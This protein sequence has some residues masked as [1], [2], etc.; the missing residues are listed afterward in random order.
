M[1]F[2]KR[3]SGLSY[4]EARGLEKIGMIECHML[5]AFNVTGSIELAL[6]DQQVLMSQLPVTYPLWAEPRHLFMQC[7]IHHTMQ[8]T[9]ITQE[10]A[11]RFQTRLVL[12]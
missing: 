1:S 6:S 12:L 2:A 7:Q 4:D 10:E 9:R 8:E 5:G 11:W 3:I